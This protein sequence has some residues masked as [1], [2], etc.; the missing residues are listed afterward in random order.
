MI[1]IYSTNSTQLGGERTGDKEDGRGDVGDAVDRP[2][3]DSK[4][5]THILAI[6]YTNERYFLHK[7]SELASQTIEIHYI[8]LENFRHE[9][10]IFYEHLENLLHTIQIYYTQSKVTTHN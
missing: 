3:P 7:H 8:Q 2:P 9:I 6:Y 4:F 1:E 5:T 10:A